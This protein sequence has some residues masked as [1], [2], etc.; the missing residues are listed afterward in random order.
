M[1]TKAEIAAAQ[2]AEAQRVQNLERAQAQQAAARTTLETA[3]VGA[4]GTTG[5]TIFEKALAGI[6]KGGDAG[7]A[8]G[9]AAMSARYGLQG[10]VLN[11]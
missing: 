8:R 6:P 5:Q 1:A 7:A 11:A 10:A 3:Q 2:R 4:K 9:L